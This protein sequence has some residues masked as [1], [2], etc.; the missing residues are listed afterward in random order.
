MTKPKTSYLNTTK[1]PT[2][3]T[4]GSK[5]VTGYSPVVKPTT[6]FTETA[7]NDTDYNFGLIAGIKLNSATITMD[8]LS[9]Y[10][11]GYLTA[12]PPNQLNSKSKTSYQEVI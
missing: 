7:K 1:T 10:L 6:T 3:Y 8:S 2:S 12:T 11:H 5:V 4:E 9:V